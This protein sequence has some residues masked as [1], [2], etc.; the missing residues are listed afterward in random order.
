MKLLVIDVGNT[1]TA[2][3]LWNDGKVSHVTHFD[4]R[5]PVDRAPARNA[6]WILSRGAGC[7][8]GVAYLSVVPRVDAGWRRFVTKALGLRFVPITH[9]LFE[10]QTAPC[11][12]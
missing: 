1:S 5:R 11:G 2:V 7:L 6:A 10:Q 3:G 8:A 9:R 12:L 4:G